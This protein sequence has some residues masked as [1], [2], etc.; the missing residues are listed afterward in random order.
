MYIYIYICISYVYS[1]SILHILI[2]HISYLKRNPR[3]QNTLAH[4][5]GPKPLKT[6]LTINVVFPK[7][8]QKTNWEDLGPGQ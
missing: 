4:I 2:L 7:L 6:W 5:I 8:S 3:Q 1:M